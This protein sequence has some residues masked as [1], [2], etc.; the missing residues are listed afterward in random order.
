MKFDRIENASKIGENLASYLR[1]LGRFSYLFKNF[2]SLLRNK[3]NSARE[4]EADELE[5]KE[6]TL[7]L[8]GGC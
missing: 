6:G 5:L 4:R 8:L 1:E 3:E 7:L 2:F